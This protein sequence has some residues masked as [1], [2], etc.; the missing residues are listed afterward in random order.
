MGEMRF[1]SILL[2]LSLAIGPGLSWAGSFASSAAVPRVVGASNVGAAGAIGAPGASVSSTGGIQGSLSLGT[3]LP[4]AAS[5]AV[6]A[7]RAPVSA[8]AQGRR[9]A[10]ESQLSFDFTPKVEAASVRPAGP[11]ELSLELSKKVLN[12]IFDE[13]PAV[14]EH[15]RA[16]VDRASFRPLLKGIDEPEA[17]REYLVGNLSYFLHDFFASYAKANSSTV[18]DFL[19]WAASDDD[20]AKATRANLGSMLQGNTSVRS[21]AWTYIFRD[22]ELWENEFRRYLR[23][24]IQEKKA[25]GR[26]DLDLDSV[27]A[28]Y[29]AEPYSL[30]ITVFE[31]LKKAGEDPDAWDVGIRSYDISVLSLLSMK[32]GIY[33]SP[34][35]GGYHIPEYTLKRHQAEKEKGHFEETG[36]EKHTRVAETLRGWIKPVY[37]DLNDV[38]QHRP[39]EEARP[40]AVFANYV[41]THL[42]LDP[43]AEL[44]ERWLSGEWSDHGFLSMAQTA[45]AEVRDR[46][47]RQKSLGTLGS[48]MPF[49]SRF[50]LTVGAIGG[51]RF[52]ESRARRP[53]L[54]DMIFRHRSLAGKKVF[55]SSQ[56]F[57]S[58]LRKDPFETGTLSARMTAEVGRLAAKSGLRV[59]LTTDGALMSGDAETGTLHLNVGWVLSQGSLDDKARLELLR[60]MWDE[61]AQGI[62]GAKSEPAAREFY[63]PRWGPGHV[64][65][66]GHTLEGARLKAVKFADDSTRL[67]W[68]VPGKLSP[69]TDRYK[70]DRPPARK[71]SGSGVRVTM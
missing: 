55:E 18:E 54:F 42:R 21:E 13:N 3:A 32:E 38:R 12:R 25:A 62:E 7:G 46:A 15:L 23:Q 40:D 65:L 64:L 6:T 51:A 17:F 29:G 10:K 60:K 49:L 67:I 33:R 22:S 61:H 39:L 56:E 70:D 63:D 27:G 53:K 30:A 5:P 69:I 68:L 19:A 26:M 37:A 66:E 20:A 50:A 45:V 8:S 58:R 28:A 41:L 11:T 16:V 2:S 24:R 9:S 36:V 48:G 71:S 35:G 14:L 43:A 1:A 31:E 4:T 57:M 34:E 47:Y 52:G 44:A 59:N